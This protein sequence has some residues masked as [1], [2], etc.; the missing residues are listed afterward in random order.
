M[1]TPE[2]KMADAIRE[3]TIAMQKAIDDG[4]RSRMLDAD[5]LVEVLLSIADRLDPPVAE[6]VASEFA[7]PD[8]GERNPDRLV[9]ITDE[10]PGAEKFVR[11]D[12]CGTIFDPTE[13]GP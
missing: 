13:G 9:W 11:C 10:F 12:A 5:D 6:S 7:C 3:V 4:Y 8:C 2:L 1:K